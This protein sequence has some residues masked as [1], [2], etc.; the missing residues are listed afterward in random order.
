MNSNLMRQTGAARTRGTPIVTYGV[1]N[2][3][4][5]PVDPAA[6]SLEKIRKMCFLFTNSLI[7]SSGSEG[8]V[9]Y[10]SGFKFLNDV[11]VVNL[12]QCWRYA[13]TDVLMPSISF[14]YE[15][16]MLKQNVSYRLGDTL[17]R[18]S[19]QPTLRLF[20]GLIFYA[21]GTSQHRLFGT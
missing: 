2:S 16:M 10:A 20:V 7:Y 6:S 15:N 8:S 13:D 19:C 11:S 4:Y 9:T 17:T 1:T 5:H 12:Y 14:Q 21:S 18:F 3:P